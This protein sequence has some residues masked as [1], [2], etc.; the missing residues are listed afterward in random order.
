MSHFELQALPSKE[1][2][3]TLRPIGSKT[4]RV[5][6]SVMVI[7]MIGGG[8]ALSPGT[9]GYL[10]FAIGALCAVA[11]YR[12]TQRKERW[13]VSP[14]AATRILSGFGKSQE[15]F[16]PVRVLATSSTDDDQRRVVHLELEHQS[17]K[18]QIG[19]HDFDDDERAAALAT[20]M[21]TELG[22]E[23]TRR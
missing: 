2:E 13:I 8:W 4:E 23:L 11:L 19:T 15:S 14:G 20:T 12:T 17:G 6:Y 10:M 7:A 1:K 16:A 18:V 9:F 22:V 21:A 5:V 3:L